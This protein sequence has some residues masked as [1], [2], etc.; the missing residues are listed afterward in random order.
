[1]E[2][3]S[4]GKHDR[5]LA[6]HVLALCE[7]WGMTQQVEEATHEVEVL[8]LVFT[9]DPDLV[10]QV[11]VESYPTFTDHRVVTCQTTFG[12]QEVTEEAVGNQFLC[13][14]GRRYGALDFTS[15][16]WQEVRE[17]LARLEWDS[18]K[19]VA[20]QSTTEAL[21][22]FHTKVLS[23]LE[24]LVPKRKTPGKKNMS[25][26]RKKIWARLSKINKRIMK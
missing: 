4:A 1:M 7:R 18:L 19:E 9:S 3:T 10:S 5:L 8:D 20:S 15:A 14:N 17:E 12:Y 24:K 25:K 16:T 26:A 22:L 21:E 13:E 2:A 11:Q 23:V 6:Q